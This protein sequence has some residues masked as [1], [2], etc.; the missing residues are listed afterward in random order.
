MQARAE[1]E[2]HKETL[3]KT[4]RRTW[5][6]LGATMLSAMASIAEVKTDYDRTADF[7]RYRTYT[8]E[9][10]HVENPLCLDRIKAAVD[11]ALTAKGWTEVATGG[12]VSIMGME[13]TAQRRTLRTYYDTYGGGWG[14]GWGWGGGIGTATTT[15]DTYTVG[16]LVI[17]LFDTNTKKLI[18]RGSA[19]K[20][21]SNSTEKNIK[22]IGKAIRKMFDRT[23]PEF[24]RTQ[25]WTRAH[26]RGGSK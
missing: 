12:D 26:R 5:R 15:E 1:L 17:D 14:W 25:E 6:L 2:P 18:W 13:M 23:P 22:L 4:Y 11:S 20:T 8:W 21:L 19:S 10:V 3:M 7:G 9:K 24:R 16:T